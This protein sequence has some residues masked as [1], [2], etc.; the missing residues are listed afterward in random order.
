M[1]I[2]CSCGNGGSIGT[3]DF[4]AVPSA[5][6]VADQ[7]EVS[8]AMGAIR[9]YKFGKITRAIANKRHSLVMKSR[10]HN[11]PNPSRFLDKLVMFINKLEKTIAWFHMVDL[12][13]TTISA[14]KNLFTMTI[15]VIHSIAKL[16]GN[17]IEIPLENIFRS[18]KKN[19]EKLWPV[20]SSL[21]KAA[22]LVSI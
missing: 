19:P 22:E 16:V 6:D 4:K 20:S 17:E 21:E 13:V 11:F 18:G 7:R 9:T 5:L 15:P 1:K 10:P 12:A 8:P 14:E 3:K 2:E